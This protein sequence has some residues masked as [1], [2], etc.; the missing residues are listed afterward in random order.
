MDVPP[1]HLLIG[2][3]E[4][5]RADNGG[6]RNRDLI[7]RDA[8]AARLPRTRLLGS[9]APGTQRWSPLDHAGLAEHRLPLI[10]WILQ[11]LVNRLL[12]PSCPFGRRNTLLSQ[13]P[14]HLPQRQAFH[15]NP[16]EDLLDDPCLLEHDLVLRLTVTSVFADVL[17]AIGSTTQHTDRATPSGMPLPAAAA[18]HNLRPLILRNHSLH[19]QK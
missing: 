12:M 10:G 2:R 5:F 8:A 15:T 7:L 16:L 4:Q 13:T 14:R 3:L 6:H 11:Q 19:L 18:F 9:A 17:V 1:L